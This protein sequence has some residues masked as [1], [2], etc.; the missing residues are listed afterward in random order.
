MLDSQGNAYI[1][2]RAWVDG[3]EDEFSTF[4]IDNATGDIDWD[5]F[6]G[7]AAHLDD[8]GLD[9]AVGP[10]DNPVAI[11][12]LQNADASA[13]LMVVKYDAA[14]GGIDWAVSTQEIVNDLS[15]DGWVAV[16][17]AGDVIVCCKTWG[18]AT[19]F[20]VTLIKYDGDDGTELWS[21]VYTNGTAADDPADM[22]LDDAGN[23][24]VVGVTAGNYLT[25]KFDGVNGDPLWTSTYEG[26]QGWYDVANCVTVGAQGEIL[27]SGFSDGTGTS[28]DVATVGYEPEFGGENWS[29]RYDGVENLTDEAKDIF[30]NT[31]GTLYVVGY[32]YNDGSGMDQLVLSYDNNTGTGVETTPAATVR[33]AAAPNPFNPLTT[34]RFELVSSARVE[35]K[36]YDLAGRRV[37]TLLDGHAVAGPHRISWSGRGDDGGRLPSGAYLARLVTDRGVSSYKVVLAK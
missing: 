13:T 11:G 1:T 5:E 33:L 21:E 19:S 30:M 12:L 22:V 9:I 16:D 3:H 29:L 32:C 23:P 15:A 27:V 10:D 14:S 37:A 35:L 31:Q 6:E 8:R 2:G 26:P 28:W 36:I 25:A 34:F 20:D 7:G 24:I 4:R 17:A 18:G